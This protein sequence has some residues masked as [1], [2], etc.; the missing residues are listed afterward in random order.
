MRRVKFATRRGLGTRAAGLAMV[1]AMLATPSVSLAASRRTPDMIGEW[2]APIDMGVPAINGTLL[3]NG[4]VLLFGKPEDQ[5]GSEAHP[6]DPVDG[7]NMDIS[8]TGKRNLFCTGQIVLPDGR[9]LAVGGELF[10]DER[11]GTQQ[12]TFLD[13]TTG[14]WT[15]GPRMGKARWYP[16]PVELAGGRFLVF[17]G[18]ADRRT[19]PRSGESLNPT[20]TDFKPLPDSADRT[21]GLYP[22]MHLLPTGRLFNPVA[23]APV[24]GQ[25][26]GLFNPA[27][28]RWR[29]AGALIGGPRFFANAVLLPGLTDVLVLGG[30][31]SMKGKTGTGLAS[32]QIFDTR[33]SAQTWEM[34]DPMPARQQRGAARRW[35]GPGGRRGRHRVLNRSRLRG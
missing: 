20:A 34:T 32:A 2:S 21:V 30:T 35:H 1:L 3:P 15:S 26:P 14:V 23:E 10:G 4:E 12:T 5:G 16:T 29:G 18:Q 31:H 6:W 28:N 19:L 13:A 9:L 11:A 33:A 25:H 24:A 8:L 17:G 7:S 27:T 22:A